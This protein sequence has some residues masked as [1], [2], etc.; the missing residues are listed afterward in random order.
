MKKNGI[1]FLSLA[2]L[3]GPL[4]FTII[5]LIC[6]SLRPN[7]DHMNEFISELGATGT[8]HADLMNF[9]GFIPSGILM[10]TFG[11]VHL[12]IRIERNLLCDLIAFTDR[13]LRTS[14]HS[15]PLF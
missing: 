1:I 4:L 13:L 6:S 15:I 5:T 12:K 8:S 7:Y 10:A 3:T 14:R 9:A 11:V 2:G